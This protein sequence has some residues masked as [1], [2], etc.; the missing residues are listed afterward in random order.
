MVETIKRCGKGIDT[1]SKSTR[2]KNVRKL[3][4]RLLSSLNLMFYRKTPR[5]LKMTMKKRR[6]NK[7]KN[8]HNIKWQ[9]LNNLS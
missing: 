4:S 7:C 2:A 3:V 9:L 1:V 6:R 8:L 5:D